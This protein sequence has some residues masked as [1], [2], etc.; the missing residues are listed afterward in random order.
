MANLK[1]NINLARLTNVGCATIKGV[2]CVVI[3]I[4]DNDIFV[5]KDEA[6]AYKHIS[7][8]VNIWENKEGADQYGNTHYAQQNYSKEFREAH[9]DR[10]TYLGNLKPVVFNQQQADVSS[11]PPMDTDGDDLPF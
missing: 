1:G 11:L 2:P 3:P 9:P 5:S 10:K 6:G 4:K 7:L 8:S